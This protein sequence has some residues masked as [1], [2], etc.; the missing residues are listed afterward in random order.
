[1]SRAFACPNCDATAR[2][3]PSVPCASPP[4]RAWL[5]GGR[6]WP[7][8]SV[9]RGAASRR[10][11]GRGI[12]ADGTLC[13]RIPSTS[14]SWATL[15]ARACMV[16]RGWVRHLR[17]VRGRVQGSRDAGV[18]RVRG[19]VVRG[20]PPTYTSRTVADAR[21]L[22]APAPRAGGVRSGRRKRLTAPAEESC[23]STGASRERPRA[24]MWR[25]AACSEQRRPTSNRHCSADGIRTDRAHRPIR[26]GPPSR[27]AIAMTVRNK[28]TAHDRR[29]GG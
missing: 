29:P 9:W 13:R 1:M 24:K 12:G 17:R 10:R 28:S 16:A 7:T 23:R 5:W 8:S 14:R 15:E 2:R 25:S 11:N 6:P 26:A 4:G 20:L 19:R 22:G 21:R 18:D 27:A 3:F